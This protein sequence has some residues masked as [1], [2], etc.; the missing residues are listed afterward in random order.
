MDK[1][2]VY[3]DQSVI[4]V[5]SQSRSPSR[6]EL[7]FK[8]VITDDKN[9]S[10]LNAYKVKNRI[11]KSTSK[12]SLTYRID[13][14]APIVTAPEGKFNHNPGA[15]ISPITL[16]PSKLHLLAEQR[17]FTRKTMNCKGGAVFDKLNDVNTFPEV[18]QKRHLEHRG[19][20]IMF[21]GRGDII[22]NTTGC[23]TLLR[24]TSKDQLT[25][26]GRA[27]DFKDE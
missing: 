11:V 10:I 8:H 21:A 12:P 24:G 6:K 13:T 5:L 27:A 22:D 19:G 23:S 9:E 3:D 26:P 7:L 25:I 1:T 14:S 2:S 20:G 16:T 17:A 18:I 4:H 15:R